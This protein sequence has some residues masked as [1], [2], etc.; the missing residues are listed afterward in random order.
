MEADMRA[1]FTLT[2]EG[3]MESEEPPHVQDGVTEGIGW[4]ALADLAVQIRDTET[5]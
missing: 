3:A 4:M 2:F 1:V 5:L